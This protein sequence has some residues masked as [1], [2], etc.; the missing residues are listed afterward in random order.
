MLSTHKSI[1]ALAF[2]ICTIQLQSCYT[3]IQ[4]DESNQNET[5]DQQL[6]SEAQASGNSIIEG[7]VSYQNGPV[8]AG[9]PAQKIFFLKDFMWTLNRPF[10]GGDIVYLLGSVDDTYI[11]K[12]VLV[13]GTYQI[14]PGNE[15]DHTTRIY[16]NVN[17]IVLYY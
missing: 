17:K 14:V 15:R 16:F 5:P 2:L 11:D 8:Q 9:R 13:V 10:P 7:I 6:Y 1:L 4:N 12:S 3:D